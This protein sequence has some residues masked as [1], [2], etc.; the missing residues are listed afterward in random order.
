M[1]RADELERTGPSTVDLDRFADIFAKG[2]AEE[3]QELC[4]SFEVDVNDRLAIERQL[5]QTVN[6]IR[7]PNT[8]SR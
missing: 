1:K 5:M 4:Q 2:S 6:P 3:I 8:N 7:S